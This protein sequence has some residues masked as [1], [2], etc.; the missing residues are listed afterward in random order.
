MSRHTIIVKKSVYRTQGYRHR[1]GRAIFKMAVRLLITC[2][3]NPI[4]NHTQVPCI[5]LP[6]DL[7]NLRTRTNARLSDKMVKISVPPLARLHET[8][9][10]Y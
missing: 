1:T 4:L 5:D 7:D 3:E 6:T 9:V 10:G 2:L 8:Y